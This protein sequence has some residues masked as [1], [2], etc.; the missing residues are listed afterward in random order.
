MFLILYMTDQNGEF[1][2]HSINYELLLKL[3]ERNL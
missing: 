2:I 3:I 1:I